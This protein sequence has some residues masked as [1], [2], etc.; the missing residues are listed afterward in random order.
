MFRVVGWSTAWL[1]VVKLKSQ[2][3]S[4]MSRNCSSFSFGTFLPIAYMFFSVACP[5]EAQSWTGWSIQ[6]THLSS[7]SFYGRCTVSHHSLPTLILQNVLKFAVPWGSFRP[8][9]S[10]RGFLTILFWCFEQAWVDFH[11]LAFRSD[12]K[13]APKIIWMSFVIFWNF[14]I[15]SAPIRTRDLFSLKGP[16]K[17]EF[18]SK[19]SQD[20]F[21]SYGRD[22]FCYHFFCCFPKVLFQHF[23]PPFHETRS[24]SLEWY[25]LRP[26]WV[27]ELIWFEF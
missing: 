8:H 12:R 7:L 9:N 17:S 20:V 13:H 27:P 2:I 10:P 5:P 6:W 25:Q 16:L 4:S 26:E 21:E 24:F 14:R 22:C 3:Q 15:S 19:W 11:D 23:S 18:V 1:F